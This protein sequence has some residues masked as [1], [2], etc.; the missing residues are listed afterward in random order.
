MKKFISNIYHKFFKYRFEPNYEFIDYRLICDVENI[1]SEK[2]RLNLFNDIDLKD[3]K[4]VL[5][6]GCGYGVNLKILKDINKDLELN[7][8][9]VSEN[10]IKMLNIINENIYKMSIR[11]IEM[12]KLNNLTNRFDFVFTDAVLIY[13]NP[14]NIKK[15]LK[16]LIDSSK[17]KILFHELSYDFDK[18]E[19]NHLYI[20]DYKKIIN[21]INPKLKIKVLKSKKPGSPWSKHG[22]LYII[23][24]LNVN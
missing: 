17:K 21:Q 14:N 15:L 18:S 2:Y 23:D 4:S 8:M 10:K 11:F 3:L 16:Q 7:A 1:E 12:N 9:E 20:H 19:I 13:V 6:Y 22:T 5:D 24:K